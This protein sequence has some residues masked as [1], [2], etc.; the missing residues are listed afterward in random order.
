MNLRK[1]ARTDRNYAL[2]DKIRDE[3]KQKG[4]QV[5]DGKDGE[6]TWIIE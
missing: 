1:K 3:L 4:V 2:S 5:M 6:M